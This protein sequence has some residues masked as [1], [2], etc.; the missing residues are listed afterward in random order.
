MS[1]EEKIF[2]VTE[3]SILMI[4][5]V[6]TVMA[7]IQEVLHIFSVGIVKLGDLLLLFL[8]LEVIG[9]LALFYKDR[10]IPITV[11]I[12]IAITALC[13][14]MILDGKTLESIELVSH[15]AAVFLLGLSIFLIQ[16]NND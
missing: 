16:K 2:A 15:A 9:M 4:I 1:V 3:K 12:Y 14:M 13:R 11:P 5:A 8:Y 7:I 6:F 10:K